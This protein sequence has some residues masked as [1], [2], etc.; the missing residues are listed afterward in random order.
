[1]TLPRSN[2]CV[3]QACACLTIILHLE[4]SYN[5]TSCHMLPAKGWQPRQPVLADGWPCSKQVAAKEELLCHLCRATGTRT[6][7]H[8]PEPWG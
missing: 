8:L 6:P 5:S 7:Q 3:T 2:P 4:R 1:M